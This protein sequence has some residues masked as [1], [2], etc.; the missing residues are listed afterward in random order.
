MN[1]KKYDEIIE[2]NKH[3]MLF[4]EIY[5]DLTCNCESGFGGVL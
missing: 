2:N 3:E 1:F 5:Y 4:L